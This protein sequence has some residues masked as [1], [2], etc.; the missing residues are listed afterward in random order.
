VECIQNDDS[1]VPSAGEH[2]RGDDS[3]GLL[4]AFVDSHKNAK[5]SIVC[6]QGVG[7]VGVA[8][9]AAVARVRG[10]DGPKYAVIGKELESEGSR[11]KTINAGKTPIRSLDERMEEALALGVAEGNVFATSDQTVYEHSDIL[12]VC[13][14]VN[15]DFERHTAELE[16]LERGI[17]EANTKL[18]D[19]A[20]VVVLSTVPPGTC[21][22]FIRPMLKGSVDLAHSYERVTPGPKYLESVVESKR[23]YAG[24]TP[25]AAERC[26]IFLSA[27][28]AKPDENL[29]EVSTVTASETAKLLENSFRAV[30]IAFVQ[31]WARY[32]EAMKLDFKEIADAVRKR[33]SHRNLLEPRLGVGGYCLTKD[34]LFAW[35]EPFSWTP[36]KE[37]LGG[38]GSFPMCEM[39]TTI[40]ARTPD[41]VG[42]WF[43]SQMHDVKGKRVH[44]LGYSYAPDVGD[45]RHS[46]SEALI[47][48]LE[49]NGAH[50]DW[51]DP[52][53]EAV[54]P[55]RVELPTSFAGY[56]AV[57]VAVGHSEY[58]PTAFWEA[59]V[60]ADLM[61]ADAS[62]VLANNGSWFASQ[63]VRLVRVGSG[64]EQMP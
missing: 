27:I 41:V 46:P 4:K 47:R 59:R 36:S 8:M 26:R 62:S 13:L 44:V 30:N 58:K 35:S 64:R 16:I 24:L 21:E 51:S 61:V 48:Y 53:V 19:G 57:F 3:A 15:F 5:R 2:A 10:K 32:C 25:R 34:P 23:V 52:F 56:N 1:E 6:V 39:A 54:G 12:L 63:G 11:I 45:T 37:L 22:R 17:R 29:T 33:E 49:K 28:V 7:F 42:K 55:G 31:E 20:L 60:C 38:A 18:P 40:N 9:L 14:P 50:V 43:I